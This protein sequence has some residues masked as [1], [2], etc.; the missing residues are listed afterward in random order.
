M[1]IKMHINDYRET[2]IYNYMCLIQID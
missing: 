2:D 1:D